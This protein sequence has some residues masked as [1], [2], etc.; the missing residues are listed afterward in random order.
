MSNVDLNKNF[1]N[2]QKINKKQKTKKHQ[3]QQKQEV[4]QAY[5]DQEIVS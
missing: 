3:Q 5:N 1:W 2:K 4:I